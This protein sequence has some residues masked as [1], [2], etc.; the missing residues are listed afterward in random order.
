MTASLKNGLVT[1]IDKAARLAGQHL[2]GARLAD[3]QL[4]VGMAPETQDSQRLLNDTWRAAGLEGAARVLH[5]PTP[6]DLPFVIHQPQLGWGLLTVRGADTVWHGENADGA[7]L[8]LERLDGVACLSL[9]RR[10]EAKTDDEVKLGALR[11]VRDALWAHKAV[12]VDAVLATTLV[13]LLTMA[14]SLFSMQVYDRVIPNQGFNTLWVLSIG[15]ILSIVLEFVLKQVRSRIV[16]HSCNTID[17]ELS[18]WFFQRML[19]IR[20]EARPASVGTLAAQVKGFEMVRGVMTSTSLFVLTDVPFALVFL[21]MITVIGGWLV[22]V[23]L[24]AL[25]LALVTGLMFQKAIQNHTRRNLSASNR[26]AGLLVEAV[27][28][29]ESLKSSS[30]E[31]LVQGRWGKLVAETSY[32]EQNIRDYAALSQNLTA[33]FQQIT[34]VAL[35]GMGAWFVTENQ[36]TMGALLACT[37]ISNRALAPII[38]LPGVMVQWA[39]ARASIDGLEQVISLPNEA[40]AAHHMLTPRSLDTGFRFER[41]RFSYGDTQRAALEVERLDIKPGERIGLVGAIGSGKSTLLKL[42]SGLYQP[43]DGKV[44]LGDVDMALLAPAVAREMVGYL[45]QETRLFSGTLRDN[46]ILGLADPGEEAILAAARRTGLIDLVLGQP[47][48]L[49]L[50][51]T[52]GGRGVSGG[53]KQLIAVTRMLLAR[54]KIWLLDEPTGAMDSKSEARI[55]ALLAELAQEGVTMIAT[56]HKNA[57]LPLLDRLIVLQSGRIVLDGPR[58]SVL[59]KLSGKPQPVAQ[60][61]AQP[62]QPAQ[63]AAA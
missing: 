31:W 41:I 39:H 15:V 52:E 22:A 33:A 8:V 21:V 44:F 3:L 42:M 11:L 61:P 13:T 45:P 37:I 9:P 25:P 35:I 20:M 30:A 6:A 38:Q 29:I 14:T 34:N 23:P 4:H 46:L 47:R 24:V 17:H 54:P 36:M 63:G 59:A 48:G 2:P 12:F 28:G 58:D 56:T 57:L 16:D 40:D 62:V 10:A 55:V 19:G 49:A 27:D 26:K 18:E 50:E 1:L 60:P 51:I 32:A 5:S 43:A 53:Q 7:N